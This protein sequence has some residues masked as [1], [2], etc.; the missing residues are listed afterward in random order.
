M[1]PCRC[2]GRWQ[3]RFRSAPPAGGSLIAANGSRL[4]SFFGDELPSSL[5][6]NREGIA[7]AHEGGGF[8]TLIPIDHD[9]IFVC[10]DGGIPAKGA[11]GHDE[12]ECSVPDPAAQ[13]VRYVDSPTLDAVV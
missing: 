11:V 5:L 8:L 2:G 7:F 10:T 13:Q 1:S 3:R 6:R 4:Q 9:E 12:V